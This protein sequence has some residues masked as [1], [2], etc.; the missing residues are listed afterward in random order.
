MKTI[1]LKPEDA[2]KLQSLKSSEMYYAA[3]DREYDSLS[4]RAA[5]NQFA[6]FYKKLGITD[7]YEAER[8]ANTIWFD[9][10]FIYRMQQ[11]GADHVEI[12]YDLNSIYLISMGAVYK[13]ALGITQTAKGQ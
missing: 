2:L 12:R 4:H 11:S 13:K 6:E 7:S 3:A 1:L 5:A 9:Y 10:E 8:I